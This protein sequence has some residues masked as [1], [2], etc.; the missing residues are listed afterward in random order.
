M[1]VI[2]LIQEGTCGDSQLADILLLIQIR[3]PG[4]NLARA[5]YDR[6]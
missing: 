5:V 3:S 4:P 1:S 6:T 2:E